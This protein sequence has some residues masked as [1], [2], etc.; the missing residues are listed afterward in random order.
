MNLP[1]QL[2]KQLREVYFGGNWTCS[3]LKDNLAG[4]S[5]EQ[6]TTQ[7]QSFNTLVTLVYHVSYY[8][9]VQIRVLRGEALN[10]SDE[11][12]FNHPP[13][14]S[15]KDW[16]TLLEKIWLDAE[17]LAALIEQMPEDKLQDDFTDKKYGNYYR[18]L[19]GN[20]EHLHYHLGQI[21]ILKKLLI[22]KNNGPKQ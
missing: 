19:N 16:E 9:A 14:Q 8:A 18:N 7:V 20:I 17:T 4:V 3:N 1:Q 22:P 10:A 11:E 6:A 13:I 12:S 2:A 15:Q 5:W 21:A